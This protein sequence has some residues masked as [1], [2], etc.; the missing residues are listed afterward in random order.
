MPQKIY[1][2]ESGFTGNNLLAPDQRYF[3]YAS[4]ATDDAEAQEFVSELIVRYGIQGGE[5]KGS[6]LVKFNKGR[7]AID[8][9]LTKFNGRLKIS[10]SDKKFAL[11][12]K[13]SRIHLRT[14]LLRSKL[15]FL[16]NRISSVYRQYFVCRV[17]GSWCGCGANI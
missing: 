1:F 10:I 8:E 11:A 3:A 4:V 9:I 7:K 13:Y 5:L 6:K 15:A 16:W 17:H 12:C 2:D 14:L